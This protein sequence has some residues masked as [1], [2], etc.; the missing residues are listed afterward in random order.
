MGLIGRIL[1]TPFRAVGDIVKGAFKPLTTALSTVL[2]A[3]KKL[4]SGDI[5]GALGTMV[6][7]TFATAAS[8]ITGPLQM[9]RGGI[10]LTGSL[11]AVGL[12]PFGIGPLVGLAGVGAYNL[13]GG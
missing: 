9:L 2:D 1:S 7:G 6:K 13:L 12:T 10:G 4:L 8:F 11:A 3:G 5:G